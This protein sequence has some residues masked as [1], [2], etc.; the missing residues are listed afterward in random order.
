MEIPSLGPDN[1]P[2]EFP[3]VYEV[4]FLGAGGEAFEARVLEALE[5]AGVKV[6][7]ERITRRDSR[8]GRF[9]A[10]T[11]GVWADSRAHLVEIYAVLRAH[12]EV[13]WTL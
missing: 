7:R 2:I 1:D 10:V 4:K 11:V 3:C 9:V 6:Y 8:G 12:P 5:K 13:R